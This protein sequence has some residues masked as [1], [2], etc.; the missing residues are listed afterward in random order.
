MAQLALGAYYPTSTAEPLEPDDMTPE[1]IEHV[2]RQFVDAACRAEAA[3][4]DGVQVHVAHFFFLSRFVSPAVNHRTDE[5]GASTQYRA[6]IVCRIIEGI[7][8]AAPSLHICAKVNSTDLVAGGI[9]ENEALELCRIYVEAGLESVEVSGNGT[10]VAGVRPGIGEAYLRGFG[11]LA[12]HELPIP[13]IL[14]GGM[15]S[16]ETIQS[17]LERTDIELVSLSRPLLREPDWPTK[18]KVNATSESLCI[19]C[20]PLLQHAAHRCIFRLRG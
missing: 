12:A 11:T 13:V 10:S 9:E 17:V 19:S 5:W 15:R 2:I 3:G 7:R 16:G 1:Q 4:F 6:R 8:E 14:V 20:K 18:L